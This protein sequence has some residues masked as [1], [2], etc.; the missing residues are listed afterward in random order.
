MLNCYYAH[1]EQDDGAQVRAILEPLAAGAVRKSLVT[2]LAP[3]P[4]ADRQQP[5]VGVLHRSG[6]DAE[7]LALPCGRSPCFKKSARLS[8]RERG[9]W[10]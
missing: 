5:E 6:C 3:E 4:E 1:A 7:S 8:A 2:V 9:R 10:A